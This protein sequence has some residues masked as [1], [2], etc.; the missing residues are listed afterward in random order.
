MN[1][2]INKIISI[3]IIAS[4]SWH[5]CHPHKY[6]C[7]DMWRHL[8]TFHWCVPNIQIWIKIPPHSTSCLNTQSVFIY[9]TW[10]FSQTPTS[11]KFNN[12]WSMMIL[13]THLAQRISKGSK[14][15]FISDNWNVLMFS[16]YCALESFQC[17]PMLPIVYAPHPFPLI[18]DCQKV[19]KLST[20]S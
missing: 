10:Q 14:F 17:V 9:N 4:I 1:E 20:L 3:N 18:C 19:P 11:T 16:H 13:N 7:W 6:Q 12:S 15:I 8:P 2:Y 5:F